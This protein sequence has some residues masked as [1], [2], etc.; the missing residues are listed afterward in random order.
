[1]IIIIIITIFIFYNIIKYYIINIKHVAKIKN[2][3]CGR[4]NFSPRQQKKILIVRMLLSICGLFP[5]WKS[6]NSGYSSSLSPYSSSACRR[7]TNSLTRCS[8]HSFISEWACMFQ[9]V[10]FF[11]WNVCLAQMFL[12]QI[13]MIWVANM[14]FKCECINVFFFFICV[15]LWLASSWEWWVM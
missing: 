4:T 1:M 3:F 6:M 15:I 10:L 7:H 8:H 2:F 12:A 14:L 9:K 13:K 5:R 11:C